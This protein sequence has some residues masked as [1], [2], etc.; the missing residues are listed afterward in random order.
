M[1]KISEKIGEI[2][3]GNKEIIQYVERE[4]KRKSEVRLSEMKKLVVLAT[5]HA[6]K[7]YYCFVPKRIPAR[8]EK[9][10]K[11]LK[12]NG[13]DV[14]GVQV[15]E[16]Y[17]EY[18]WIV[19]VNLNKL[20]YPKTWVHLPVLAG[21]IRKADSDNMREFCRLQAIHLNRN[22]GDRVIDELIQLDMSKG[23][24]Q[25]MNELVD[26]IVNGEVLISLAG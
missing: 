12:E 10:R 24:L 3:M 13:L 9:L 18:F 4:V 6:I 23:L 8:V 26:K 21:E 15:Q 20:Y 25:A 1:I 11:T 19:P 22:L 16:R 14:E 17:G 2:R 5:D 7:A